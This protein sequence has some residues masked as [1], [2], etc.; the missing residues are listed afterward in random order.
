[1]KFFFIIHFFFKYFRYKDGEEIKPDGHIQLTANPDGSVRLLIEKCKPT[2][3]G[4]Y[5]L[6]ATNPN[7]TSQAICAVAIKRAYPIEIILKRNATFN[8][9]STQI[10]NCKVISCELV[11]FLGLNHP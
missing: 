7:G 4:A 10:V 11:N 5:K 6:I 3:C 2:D 9:K 8:L 1:M